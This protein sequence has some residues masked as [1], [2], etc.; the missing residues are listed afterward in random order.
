MLAAASP[1]PCD[2]QQTIRRASTLLPPRCQWLTECMNVAFAGSIQAYSMQEP[3]FE[4]VS[5]GHGRHKEP[6]LLQAY[7]WLGRVETDLMILAVVNLRGQDGQTV[8]RSVVQ[9]R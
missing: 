4:C 2:F 3:T 1:G 8:R 9:R 6:A 5:E 7:E